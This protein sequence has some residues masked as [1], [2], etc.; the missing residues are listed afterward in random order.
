[1]RFDYKNRI[2][3]PGDSIHL[4]DSKDVLFLP[5][6]GPWEAPIEAVRLGEKLH[7]KVIVPIHDWMWNSEWRATMYGRLEA[8]YAQQSIKFISAVDGESVTVDA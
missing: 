2:T 3:H 4:D 6:A 7:P 1:V 8:Y 5:L